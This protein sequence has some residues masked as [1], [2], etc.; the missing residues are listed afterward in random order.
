MN[1]FV[2]ILQAQELQAFSSLLPVRY[3]PY[4]TVNNRRA[5]RERMIRRTKGSY[6]RGYPARAHLAAP[7]SRLLS[8]RLARLSCF[9]F[10]SEIHASYV[11]SIVSERRQAE[12]PC[13]LGWTPLLRFLVY[14]AVNCL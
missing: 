2:Y 3:V 10:Q 13:T 1:S 6:R 12:P 7:T 8:S 14:H 11:C 9:S 4:L 5:R